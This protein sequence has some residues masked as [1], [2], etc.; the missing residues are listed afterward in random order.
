MKNITMV[1]VVALALLLCSCSF[2]TIT[3]NTEIAETSGV[4]RDITDGEAKNSDELTIITETETE[5]ETDIETET[6]EESTDPETT[7]IG[8]T[9][10][11]LIDGISVTYVSSPVSRNETAR[12]SIK[13]K[14]DTEYS[15]K[16]YYS[17][18]ASKASGLE[19]KTSDAE[20]CVS[21]SWKVGGATSAGTYRIVISGGDE[22]LETEFTVI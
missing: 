14:P 10:E 3:D 12:I 21:W 4:I 22:K 15:I 13:G 8:D 9:T 11:T 16:V 18:S 5:T 20:G 2:I 19:N 17:T 1:L 6:E 7:I